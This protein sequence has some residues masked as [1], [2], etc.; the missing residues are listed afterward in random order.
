M[1][2]SSK[3]LWKEGMFLQPHHFQVFERLQAA[4]VDARLASLMYGGYQHGFTELEV[5]RDALL[6]GNFSVSRA[7][8]VF[9]DGSCFAVGAGSL[10]YSAKALSRSFAAYCRPEQLTL[11]VYLAIPAAGGGSHSGD[12]YCPV[13]PPG[14]A[15]DNGGAGVGRY[16][17]RAVLVPDELSRD[18]NK[19]IDLGEPNYQIRFEGEPL[20]GCVWLR[21]A[22]LSRTGSGYMEL[23]RDYA[24]PVLFTRASEAL[25]NC[26][27]GLL[28]LLWARTGSLAQCRRRTEFGQAFFSASEENSFRMLNTLCMFTPLLSRLHELPKI[29][30]F[31]YYTRLTMLYGS[32]LSFSPSV[33]LEHFPPFDHDDPAASFVALA[34]RIREALR[35]EFWTNC[36]A[37]PLEQSNPTTWFCRF[38]DER[39]AAGVN[40]FIGVSAKAAQ[41]SLLVDVLQRMKVGSRDKLDLLISSS[42]QG[43]PLIHVK[44]IPEGLAAKPEFVYFVIDRQGPLWQS[45]ETSGTLGIHF[46]GG[47]YPDMKIELLALKHQG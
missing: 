16:V 35:V 21:A 37:L 25:R 38:P 31:E 30:P 5:D 22:R 2:Q 20:D 12:G 29:H 45:V 40:L 18:N 7:A 6:G 15:A 44:S 34:E 24:P 8:G 43:L 3:V 46:A 36:T 33:A 10:D 1:L 4:H 27:S 11:D 42:L 9:P 47:G 41:K 13:Q 23:R 32:L 39:F 19:E 17:E 26:V 14:G 28:E